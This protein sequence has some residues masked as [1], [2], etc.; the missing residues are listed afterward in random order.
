M[1]VS[2]HLCIHLKL[3]LSVLI[4]LTLQSQQGKGVL[5][6]KESKDEK[7]V[8]ISPRRRGRKR[9]AND[10]TGYQLSEYMDSKVIVAFLF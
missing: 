8:P 9:K 2:K 5:N 4:Q 6:D 10:M 7:S 3:L 1:Y